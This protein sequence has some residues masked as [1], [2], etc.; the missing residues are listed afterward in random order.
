VFWNFLLPIHPFL[1]RAPSSRFETAPLPI[2]PVLTTSSF[3]AFL[4]F[5][6][7]IFYMC[8]RTQSFSERNACNCIQ[9][10]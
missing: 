6:L 4:N 1:P 9:L 8:A 3:L 2:H 7:P 5:L 10:Q